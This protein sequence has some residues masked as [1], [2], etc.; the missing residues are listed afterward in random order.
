MISINKKQS[1]I[2]M[3]EYIMN[4]SVGIPLIIYFI[5]LLCYK[6]LGHYD[7][8]LA[9]I[10]L[11]CLVIL[12]FTMGKQ[13][14]RNVTFYTHNVLW[15]SHIAV[16]FSKSIYILLYGILFGVSMMLIWEW[17]GRCSLGSDDPSGEGGKGMVGNL[18]G[19]TTLLCS[20]VY[21]YRFSKNS[22]VCK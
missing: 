3:H 16:L 17:N 7:K 11:S 13:E 22:R 1:I 15:F 4:Y 8:S 21:V 9:C 5:Y 19:T 10:V 14:Y 18:V 2:Q 6:K 20:I 12:G